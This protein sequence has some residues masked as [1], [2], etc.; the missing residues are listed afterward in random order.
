MGRMWQ[1]RKAGATKKKSDLK[2]SKKLTG[3]G[4][5][6]LPPLSTQDE[7]LLDVAEEDEMSFFVNADSE[8]HQDGQMMV[9]DASGIAALNNNLERIQCHSCKFDNASIV[10]KGC[11][12]NEDKFFC[13]TCDKNHHN[14]HK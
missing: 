12:E 6:N 8:I 5:C 11:M 10:C 14:Y 7:H 1:N 2:A 13:K 4:K 3:S 9:Q